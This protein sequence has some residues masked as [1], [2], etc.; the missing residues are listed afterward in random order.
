MSK[1]VARMTT[2]ELRELI[3]EA[4]EAAVDQKLSELLDD[5]DAG[6]ELRSGLRQR[7]IRQQR[8]VT[9]GERGRPLAE[10][11]RA[12]STKR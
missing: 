10:V 4:V 6:K 2:D 8:A 3:A 1:T 12:I 11:S 5:P 9:A 7:L